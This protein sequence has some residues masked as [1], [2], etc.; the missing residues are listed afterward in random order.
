M[1]QNRKNGMEFVIGVDGRILFRQ[2][3]VW[4]EFWLA[5]DHREQF[6][7]ASIAMVERPDKR[8]KKAYKPFNGYRLYPPFRVF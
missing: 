4:R 3:W 6:G 7:L 5:I 1:D 8:M 2:V